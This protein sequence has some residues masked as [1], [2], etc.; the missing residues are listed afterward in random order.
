VLKVDARTRALTPLPLGD[1]D[2]VEV[3]DPVVAIGNP[4]GYDRTLT[5]GVVSA[6]GREISAPNSSPI[7][8][9]IQTD[10]AI[11]HGN[12]GGPL[13]DVDGQVIG[14][15]SQISTGNTGD[16]G[17]VGI[18][19]AIPINLVR[20]VAAQLI[21]T[22]K[23]EHPFIGISVDPISPQLAKLFGL[24]AQHGLLIRAVDPGSGAAKAGLKAGTT[25]VIVQGTSYRL[26]GDIIVAVNGSPVS[27]FEQLRSAL[28]SL[29]PGDK[30]HLD[31]YRNDKRKSVTVTLGSK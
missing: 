7:E 23:A 3:G 6:V 29:K 28:S 5:S 16:Q 13:I 26:G 18:G 22:G 2:A 8:N 30:L 12:S 20:N 21:K 27:T 11:N 24:P 4:F 19:F 31:I 15:T 17:N 14:V 9:A 1:S 10:A 25:S